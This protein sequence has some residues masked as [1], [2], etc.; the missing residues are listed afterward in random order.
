MTTTTIW[1]IAKRHN[2]LCR[3]RA[4]AKS[5]VAMLFEHVQKHTSLVLDSSFLTALLND[6]L[7]FKL[8]HKVKCPSTVPSPHT[9]VARFAKTTTLD[10]FLKQFQTALVNHHPALCEM[11]TFILVHDYWATRWTAKMKR[12]FKQ[13]I[14][15][16]FIYEAL[17]RYAETHSDFTMQLIHYY[18]TVKWTHQKSLLDF[19]NTTSGF[20]FVKSES[21]MFAFDR[22]F[23]MDALHKQKHLR[24][25]NKEHI[26]HTLGQEIRLC[27][28]TNVCEAIMADRYVNTLISRQNANAAVNGL[29][30]HDYG[31]AHYKKGKIVFP[32]MSQLYASMYTSWNL[33]FI[34]PYHNA[35]LLHPKL[36]FPFL[37]GSPPSLFI[38]R[39]S[40]SLWIAV[41]SWLC[42][43]LSKTPDLSAFPVGEIHPLLARL[44]QLYAKDILQLQIQSKKNKKTRTMHPFATI[45]RLLKTIKN[46]HTLVEAKPYQYYNSRKLYVPTKVSDLYTKYALK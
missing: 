10:T 43:H 31:H 11:A 27:L 22:Y 30:E 9:I 14:H 35:P 15:I 3:T 18:Y 7:H 44:N 39:R 2:T 32:Q 1:D 38:F 40:I 20:T 4:D 37:L 41:N 16:A 25:H 45:K 46:V 17:T 5:N 8:W 42:N 6:T 19:M 13:T 34:F 12:L 29:I 26:L 28:D 24:K 33:C 21:V 36:L 23:Q